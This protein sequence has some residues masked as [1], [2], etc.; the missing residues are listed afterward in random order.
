MAWKGT[1]HDEPLQTAQ[2]AAD[3]EHETHEPPRGALLIT[4]GYLVLI[5]ALWLQVYLQ[6]ISN[7]GVPRP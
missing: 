4:C 7:G 1:Q 2:P 3:E 6:L 5:C